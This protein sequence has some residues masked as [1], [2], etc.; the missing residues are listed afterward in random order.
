MPLAP[1]EA[2]VLASGKP[3]LEQNT[4]VPANSRLPISWMGTAAACS[5]AMATSA[6]TTGPHTKE[7]TNSRH[8]PSGVPPLVT[9]GSASCSCDAARRKLEEP[10]STRMSGMVWHVVVPG[11]Q[12]VTL[13]NIS[14]INPNTKS[15]LTDTG[16]TLGPVSTAYGLRRL[17]L[18]G[19]EPLPGAEPFRVQSRYRTHRCYWGADCYSMK[20]HPRIQE[21]GG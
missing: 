16:C 3:L 5:S 9:A 21:A 11:T 10:V 19:A 12:T 17:S 20:S 14:L 8:S 6:V 13:V 15:P 4:G 7:S 18:L 2:T 1:K